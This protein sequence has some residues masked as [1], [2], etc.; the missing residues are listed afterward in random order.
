MKERKE[1]NNDMK[2]KALRDYRDFHWTNSQTQ[3]DRPLM[4]L[5]SV[6]DL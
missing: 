5:D 3:E 2:E 1:K 6:I 4:S